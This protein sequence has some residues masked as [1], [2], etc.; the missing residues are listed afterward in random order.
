M[1]RAPSIQV[2]HV[3][4]LDGGLLLTFN[5]GRSAVLTAIALS[6]MIDEAKDLPEFSPIERQAMKLIQGKGRT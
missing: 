5:D 2:K 1:N 6:Q 4:I 3:E